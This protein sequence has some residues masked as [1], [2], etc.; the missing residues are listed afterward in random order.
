M[1]V[2]ASAVCSYKMDLDVIVKNPAFLAS[3]QQSIISISDRESS[4]S[5]ASGSP[6]RSPRDSPDIQDANTFYAADSVR[7]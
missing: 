2:S 6:S 3:R 7:H 1:M 5:Q 4:A